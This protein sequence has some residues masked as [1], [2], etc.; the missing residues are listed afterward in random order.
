MAGV[1]GQANP[2]KHKRINGWVTGTQTVVRDVETISFRP[3][4]GLGEKIKADM[5]ARGIAS[6]QQWCDEAVACLL[7][8]EE[9]EDSGSES[10][11]SISNPLVEDAIR[12]AI[13]SKQA[14][15]R[16]ERKKKPSHQDQA[17]IESWEKEVEELERFL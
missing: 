15:I 7:G 8:L 3:L 12:Q 4:K 2:S 10:E 16:A 14:A 1:K 9:Q 17:L 13:A 11:V 6:K 5:E